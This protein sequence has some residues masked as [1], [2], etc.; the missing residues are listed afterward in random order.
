[1]SYQHR[2]MWN[3]FTR[4]KGL[5]GQAA[6]NMCERGNTGGEESGKADSSLR[7]E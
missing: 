6:V 2:L 1:M 4:G 3:D 7:S 5:N